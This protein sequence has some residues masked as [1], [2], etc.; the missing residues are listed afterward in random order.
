M[1]DVHSVGYSEQLRQL[2]RHIQHAAACLAQPFDVLVYLHLGTDV[3]SL[4]GSFSINTLGL[5]ATHLEMTIFC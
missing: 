5:V 3:D 1:N 4:V 2:R